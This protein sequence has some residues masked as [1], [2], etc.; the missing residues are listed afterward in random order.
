MKLSEL[1]L[2]NAPNKIEVLEPVN[3]FANLVMPT[4]VVNPIYAL[5]Q[6]LEETNHY[7]I[8]DAEAKR[9]GKPA[10]YTLKE[11]KDISDYRDGLR[12]IINQL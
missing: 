1:I 3:P 4:V 12:E 7:W 10:P 11:L 9:V 2:K 8:E 5:Q 6:Q